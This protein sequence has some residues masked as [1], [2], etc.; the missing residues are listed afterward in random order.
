MFYIHFE[1]R[2]NCSIESCNNL[3]GFA[4]NEVKTTW[5][6]I[7]LATTHKNDIIL[8]AKR[9]HACTSYLHSV[10]CNVSKL[11]WEL[12]CICAFPFLSFHRN[13]ALKLTKFLVTLSLFCVSVSQMLQ[14]AKRQFGEKSAAAA[15]FCKKKSFQH[16]L[17][18]CLVY[19]NYFPALFQT[20]L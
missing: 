15:V 9:T 8:D 18:C 17:A 19:E 13:H 7:W 14:N 5:F 10:R 3:I 20:I 4:E 1:I 11:L 16:A 6:S 12:F 2:V